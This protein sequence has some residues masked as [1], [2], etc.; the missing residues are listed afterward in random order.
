MR[1]KERLLKGKCGGRVVGEH[2]NEE[3]REAPDE[4]LRLDELAVAVLM[5]SYRSPWDQLS[6]CYDNGQLYFETCQ[7][8]RFQQTVALSLFRPS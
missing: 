2:T 3:D 6:M 5:M 8:P 4:D 7:R 1:A